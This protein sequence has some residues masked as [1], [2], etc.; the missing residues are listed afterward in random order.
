MPEKP[1]ATIQRFQ[2]QLEHFLHGADLDLSGFFHPDAIWHLPRSAAAWGGRDRIGREAILRMLH[3]EVPQYYQPG[4]TRFVYHQFTCE[5]DRVHMHFTLQAIT[6]N[7][8]AYEN[9]YQTLFRLQDGMI[10]VFQD[11][12]DDTGNGRKHRGT[13]ITQQ[14]RPDLR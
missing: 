8:K 12:P 7:G 11:L 2:Q 14:G 6:A 9:E 13:R 1:L 5:Q 3:E 4:S 10:A